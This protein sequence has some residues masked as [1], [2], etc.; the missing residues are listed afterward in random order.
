MYYNFLKFLLS[1][2]VIILL[3]VSCV[4]DHGIAPKAFVIETTGFGGTVTFF[5][6]WPD[7]I[8]RTHIVIFKDPLLAPSDFNIFNLKYVSWEI[9]Y[10]TDT[11][12]YTSID[13]SV[14]PGD[15][16]FTP[17]EYAYVAVAQQK[18]VDLSLSRKDWFVA[19]VYYLFGDTSQPGTMV[20]QE[21]KYTDNVNIIC[22]F[23]NPP[24]QPPGGN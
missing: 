24:P 23:D 20:I 9:P 15:S 7:S 19:G 13:S 16:T 17:G 10:G 12:Q 6:N 11:W 18:T 14:I 5:G 1:G 22:D 8:Q 21:D 2:S 3:I 4:N